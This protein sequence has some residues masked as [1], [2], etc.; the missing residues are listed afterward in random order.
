MI[1]KKRTLIMASIFSTA[2]LLGACG[3][4]NDDKDENVL[5]SDVVEPNPEEKSGE[6]ISEPETDYGFQEFTLTID[7]PDNQKSVIVE[8]KVDSSS[9]VYKNMHT[10]VNTEGDGAAETL[11]PV[12]KELNLKKDMN[13]EEVVQQITAAFEVDEYTAFNLDVQYDD[14]ETMNYT[15]N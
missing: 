1:Y 10:A 13:T 4:N 12:F 2:L 11:D 3:D 9:A 14:G 5:K 8:Y 7:T 15:V 6:A